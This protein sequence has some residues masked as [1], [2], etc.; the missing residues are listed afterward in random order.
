VFQ[1][2][3]VSPGTVE[4]LLLSNVT[5]MALVW[6]H[7]N[8]DTQWD[9]QYNGCAVDLKESIEI[10]NL[11]PKELYIFCLMNVDQTTVSIFD[12]ISFLVPS[13]DDAWL[14]EDEKQKCILYVA[15]SMFICM[16]LSAFIAF[17]VIKQ[18]PFL[19]QGSKRIV[20]VENQT[21]NILV[22]PPDF[23]KKKL[24]NH[25]TNYTLEMQKNNFLNHYQ[26]EEKKRINL[27][28]ISL[29]NSNK[30]YKDYDD[31]SNYITANQLMNDK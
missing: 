18:K 6:F 1:V 19:L 7:E 12:C 13:D 17:L 5:G 21:K 30:D 28:N 14:R 9:D 3:G 25:N 22:M 10:E 11:L 27:L 24:N 23:D 2:R 8:S 26:H 31:N 4:V 16:C 29:D 15:L 20:L